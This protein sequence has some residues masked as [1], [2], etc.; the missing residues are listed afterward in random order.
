M[1]HFFDTEF[2]E[3]T[4]KDYV[5]RSLMLS[6][7]IAFI[8]FSFILIQQMNLLSIIV[9]ICMG[10][11]ALIFIVTARYAKTSKT[12]DLIS[13][14][15]V[16]DDNREYYAVSKDFN[17][18]EAWSRF[19][20]KINKQFPLGPEENKEYWIRDNVIKPIFEEFIK[21]EYA[22]VEK[23]NRMGVPNSGEVKD[24]FTYR[25]FKKLLNRYGKSNNEIA[26]EIIEFCGKPI[27]DITQKEFEQGKE[28]KW[29]IEQPVFYAYYADY[30]WVVFCWLFGRMIDLPK[31]FPMYCKDL[32][33]MLD[34]KQKYF[35]D[36]HISKSR[37]KGYKMKPQ[38]LIEEDDNYPNQENE[39]N[40]LDDAKWNKKLYQFIKNLNNV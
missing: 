27:M 15:I 25:R 24:K 2:L 16:S 21:K 3:G 10:I 32:K 5:K 23:M 8:A 39:H 35:N 18:K 34:D 11:L 17:L 40:A 12:I 4:Q 19:Q 22:L 7:G 9:G 31:G 13:I 28:A 30:D 29:N 6:L 14:G 26:E 38:Y 36:L 1:K 20:L 37:R 33:Q